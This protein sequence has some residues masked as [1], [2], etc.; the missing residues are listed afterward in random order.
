MR[1]TRT[2]SA[3]SDG[4]GLIVHDEARTTHQ[5]D[6]VMEP[7]LGQISIIGFN[8]PAATRRLEQD[9]FELTKCRIDI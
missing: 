6:N 7:F 3:A 8:T 4:A 5:K 1:H 9:S 2:V